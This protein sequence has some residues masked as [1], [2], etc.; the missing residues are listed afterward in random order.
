[1]K[2]AWSVLARAELAEIRRYSVERWGRDVAVRYLED[3]RDAARSAAAHPETLRPLRGP[4]RLRRAR[5]H[6]LILH[7]DSAAD[8][9]TVARVLHVSMDLARHLP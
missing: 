8:R 2:L 4:Y 5:S 7:V 9:L 1:M 6:V 3:L